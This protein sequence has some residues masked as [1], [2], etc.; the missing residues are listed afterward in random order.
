MAGDP[1]QFPTSVLRHDEVIEVPDPLRS[2]MRNLAAVARSR[3]AL[4]PATLIWVPADT[5]AAVRAVVNGAGA[6]TAELTLVMVDTRL[7]QVLFRTV[8][9]GGADDPWTALVRATKSATPG[10]P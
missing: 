6:A 9:R 1:A 3:F 4:V 7:G 2:Q 5:A 8:A 10:L